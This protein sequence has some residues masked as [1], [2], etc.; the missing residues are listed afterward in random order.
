MGKSTFFLIVLTVGLITVSWAHVTDLDKQGTVLQTLYHRPVHPCQECFK[1][2]TFNTP[3]GPSASCCSPRCCC[4]PSTRWPWCWQSQCG[5]CPLRFVLG[6]AEWP[7]C[8]SLSLP[9]QS[10]M[11]QQLHRLPYH[12]TF[13]IHFFQGSTALLHTQA[14]TLDINGQK[15]RHTFSPS[16]SSPHPFLARA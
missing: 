2:V 7:S 11:A 4:S 3:A 13:H 1:P 9:R 12:S 15:K 16:C 14:T 8:F 5:H 10:P 6:S